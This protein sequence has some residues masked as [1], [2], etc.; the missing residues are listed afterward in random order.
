M[1]DR[2]PDKLL[3]LG[4]ERHPLFALGDRVRTRKGV[5]VVSY[6]YQT[7]VNYRRDLTY[8]VEIEGRRASGIFYQ[9]ELTLLEP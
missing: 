9:R 8:R 6:V 4:L 1:N 2:V 7:P 3:D 5:G